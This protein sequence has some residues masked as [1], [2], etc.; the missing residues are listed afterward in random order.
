VN[1]R[2]FT[3]WNNDEIRIIKLR[4]VEIRTERKLIARVE[5]DWKFDKFII[6]PEF[7]LITVVL[8]LCIMSI[9]SY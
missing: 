7:K 1:N 3:L 6:F 8:E 2:K 9:A 5:V 4:R